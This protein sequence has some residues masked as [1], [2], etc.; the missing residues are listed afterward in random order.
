MSYTFRIRM[1]ILEMKHKILLEINMPIIYKT[2]EKEINK[3]MI[4]FHKYKI[5]IYL[6]YYFMK[7][8]T[9]NESYKIK[10]N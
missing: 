5:D 3:T 2:F 9:F 1:V 8:N 10:L 4:Y 6:Q 7:V